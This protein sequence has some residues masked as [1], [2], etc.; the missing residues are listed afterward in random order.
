[1]IGQ[2]LGGAP[3]HVSERYRE[4][5]PRELLPIGSRQ[6][7]ITGIHDATILREE[8]E[9]YVAAAR[10]AGDHVEFI[11]PLDAGHF[12]VIAPT[13]AAWPEIERVILSLVGVPDARAKRQEPS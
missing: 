5:S 13:S 11:Q 1:V 6:V 10:A 9:A 4:A 2:L 8:N 3:D 12:E 7:L